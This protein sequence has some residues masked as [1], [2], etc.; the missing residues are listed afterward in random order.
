MAI[1]KNDGTYL[2][3][4]EQCARCPMYRVAPHWE[5]G[6]CIGTGKEVE[7]T[8]AFLCGP[9]TNCPEGYWT[10]LI[11]IDLVARANKQ[12]IRR[13]LH[14][15]KYIAP[16]IAEILDEIG[17]AAIKNKILAICEN[18]NLLPS[19]VRSDITTGK[20]TSSNQPAIRLK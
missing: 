3:R 14:A 16:I 15:R 17:S 1:Q 18:R 10:G 11:P 19:S 20:I 2:A 8:D 5:C 6:R 13:E 7:R 9:K 12:R 4:T